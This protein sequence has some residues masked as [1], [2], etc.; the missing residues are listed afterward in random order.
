MKYSFPLALVGVLSITAVACKR[1]T[2][3]DSAI[4]SA[5]STSISA[6]LSCEVADG[7]QLNLTKTGESLIFNYSKYM[8]ENKAEHSFALKRNLKDSKDN[9]T[10]LVYGAEGPAVPAGGPGPVVMTSEND[11]KRSVQL[12]DL[13]SSLPVTGIEVNGRLD[14][15]MKIVSASVSVLHQQAG[16]ETYTNQYLTCKKTPVEFN[17]QKV[18]ASTPTPP[19]DAVVLNCEVA[20]AWQLQ[21]VRTNE[22]LVF[23][24]AKTVGA[25]KAEHSFA[26]KR[27]RKDT[28]DNDTHLVYGAEG[29]AVPAGGPGPVVI[30]NDND[31]KR[32]VQLYDFI[33]SLPLTGVEVNGNLSSSMKIVSASVSVLHQQAGTERYTNKYLTC[34]GTPRVFLGF[35]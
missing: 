10:H 4:E 18:L 26:L 3:S 27:T 14:S 9:D 34:K 1:R 22:F 31:V 6:V 17:G 29:A 20:D 25:N 32:A 30:A 33:S 23:N 24:Y 12:F 5:A 8:G 11:V 2:F 19:P 21:L 16:T 15:S 35:K 28:N 13:I 7:W